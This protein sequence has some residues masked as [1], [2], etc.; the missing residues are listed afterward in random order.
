MKE[1]NVQIVL[2]SARALIAQRG[3]AVSV[4][5]IAATSG[6]SHPAV[7]KKWRNREALLKA[8]HVSI[9]GDV[10]AA[11]G[12]EPKNET[13]SVFL[14]KA[15]FALQQVDDAPDY[16]SFATLGTGLH[17]TCANPLLDRLIRVCTRHIENKD[18][19]T[20]TNPLHTEPTAMAAA[21][22]SLLIAFSPSRVKQV[23]EAAGTP[24]GIQEQ[25]PIL[26]LTEALSFLS[27]PK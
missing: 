4:R 3:E 15:S 19:P 24:P 13:L 18:K 2:N 16:Y 10:L 12:P 25:L 6:L 7:R 8:V 20:G 11:L 26:A 5:E 21:I 22:F 1:A 14:V 27:G 9:N 17:T 23:C